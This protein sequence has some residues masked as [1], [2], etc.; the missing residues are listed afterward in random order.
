M[1]YDCN[2][3]ILFLNFK[4]CIMLRSWIFVLVLKDNI[5]FHTGISHWRE[6]GWIRGRQNRKW[7]CR[8][9]RR[10]KQMYHGRGGFWYGGQ[11]WWNRCGKRNDGEIRTGV[12]YRMVFTEKSQSDGDALLN[13]LNWFRNNEWQYVSGAV[14]CGN[15]S[16]SFRRK[17]F[18]RACVTYFVLKRWRMRVSVWRIEWCNFHWLY[19]FWFLVFPCF[20]SLSIYAI[21]N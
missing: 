7:R 13:K 9:F 18:L 6:T 21:N 20:M 2:I 3:Y 16:V 5:L 8:R 11:W 1:I 12:R 19:L 17:V 14:R 4:K 10:K 15:P